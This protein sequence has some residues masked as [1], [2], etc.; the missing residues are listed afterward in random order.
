MT[1]CELV[2]RSAAAPDTLS[3]SEL[4]HP[5][6][7][8][9]PVHRHHHHHCHHYHH[10]HNHQLAYTLYCLLDLMVMVQKRQ[11]LVP[12]TFLQKSVTDLPLG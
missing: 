5:I 11:Q 1:S 9:P 10:Y 12:F 8:N 4:T 6:L 3:S 7:S 2:K